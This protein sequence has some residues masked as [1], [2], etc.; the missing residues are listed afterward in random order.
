MIAVSALV[1]N[2]CT[3]NAKIKKY[4]MIAEKTSF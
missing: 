2:V 4:L 3:L 1:L